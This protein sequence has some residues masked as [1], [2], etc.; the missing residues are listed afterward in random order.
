MEPSEQQKPMQ[1][2]ERIEKSA[3]SFSGEARVTNI[4]VKGDYHAAATTWMPPQMVPPRASSLVGRETE[5]SK[6]AVHLA[7]ETGKIVGV[8]GAG[9]MGKTALAAE[10]VTRLIAQADWLKR[11][12]GGCF[13]YSFY[14]VPSLDR[15]FE[16]LAYYAGEDSKEDPHQAAL[17]ALSCRR[18]L[19]IFDGVE[20][21]AD[22][23]PLRQLG[24]RHIVLILSRRQSDVPDQR[25]RLD[26]SLLSPDLARVLLCTL[27]GAR[28]HDES[29]ATRLVQRIGGYPLALQLIGSYL[30]SQQEDIADYLSWFEEEGLVA[31]DRGVHQLESVPLLL[32][33]TYEAL[34]PSEQALFMVLGLLAP[35]AFPLGLAQGILELPERDVRQALGALVKLSVLRRP[36]QGYEVSHP[37]IHTFVR[38]Q[39]ARPAYGDPFPS[40]ETIGGWRARLLTTLMAHFQ[41]SDSYDRAAYALWQP[42][43]LS[44]LDETALTEQQQKAVAFLF[45]QVAFDAFT[46]GRYTEAEPLYQCALAIAEEQLGASHPQTAGSLNNLALL[47]ESQGRYTEAEPLY[48]R[49]LAIREEQLGASHPD[50]A[51]SLNNLAALYYR[52]GRYTEAEPLYQR[53]VMIALTSLGTKHPQ[54]QQIMGN[55]LTL[56]S[57]L[58]TNGDMDTLLGLL[59]Q[60]EQEGNDSKEG[61]PE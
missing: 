51:G 31:L 56:L 27:A 21:I 47:Y 15:A 11:F 3:V 55:Y 59:A 54:T 29:S 44:W 45:N 16:E 52:Q 20:N 43:V 2:I 14:G 26:L 49:A 42:H 46:Q 1:H 30:S 38:E 13:Y 24:G 12:P 25:N 50:T 33:R 4:E 36:E 9:G 39:L 61:L 37:L 58:Y 23:L 57:Q 18:M 8:C 35:V 48:Q 5:L 17:R 19:L 34:K 6:L 53:A 41:Q 7:D 10:A 22:S 32:R 40:L 60:R 28:A